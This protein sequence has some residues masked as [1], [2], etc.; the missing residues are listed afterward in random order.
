MSDGEGIQLFT[1]DGEPVEVLLMDENDQWIDYSYSPEDGFYAYRNSEH[2]LT[3]V[4]EA[5]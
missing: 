4:L 2:S 3:M 5:L 1:E